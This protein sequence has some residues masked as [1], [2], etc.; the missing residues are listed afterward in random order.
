MKRFLPIAL[1]AIFSAAPV[2]ADSVTDT[3]LAFDRKANLIVL[4]DKTVFTLAQGDAV[5]PDGL[6]AGDV[7]TITYDSL[8]EDGYG[9]VTSITVSQ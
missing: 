3:V 9:V 6:K 7:V 2:L 5:A 4:E 8:G 1:T